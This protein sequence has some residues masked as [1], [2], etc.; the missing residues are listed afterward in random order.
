MDDVEVA[1]QD[2][3]TAMNEP[4]LMPAAG[5]GTGGDAANARYHA[6]DSMPLCG[7]HRPPLAAGLGNEPRLRP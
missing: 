1:A 5:P 4:D 2:F 3:F 6:Y 7:R